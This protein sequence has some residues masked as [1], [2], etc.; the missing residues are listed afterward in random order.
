MEL[1]VGVGVSAAV[2]LLLLNAMGG[3]LLLIDKWYRQDYF[4]HD[5]GHLMAGVTMIVSGVMCAG[6]F[7]PACRRGRSGRDLYFVLSV[8]CGGMA[9]GFAMS[10]VWD[11]PYILQHHRNLY[12]GHPTSTLVPFHAAESEWIL[13]NGWSIPPYVDKLVLLATACGVLTT[14]WLVSGAIGSKSSALAV[15]RVIGF[16]IT[17]VVLSCSLIGLTLFSMSEHTVNMYRLGSFSDKYGLRSD[18]SSDDIDFLPD[19]W[20]KSEFQ[21]PWNQMSPLTLPYIVALKAITCLVVLPLGCQWYFKSLFSHVLLVLSI[22]ANATMIV[23]ASPVIKWTKAAGG[24]LKK[25]SSDGFKGAA[26]GWNDGGGWI[27]LSSSTQMTIFGVSCLLLILLEVVNTILKRMN[28][29]PESETFSDVEFGWGGTSVITNRRCPKAKSWRNSPWLQ[30]HF[31]KNPKNQMT[32][33]TSPWILAKNTKKRMN[34]NPESETFSDVEF[35]WGG[36]SVITNRRCPKA[37]SWRNSPWLQTH[38]AK[39]PKNQMTNWTSPWI[40]AKNTKK[41]KYLNLQ[42]TDMMTLAC[43]QT[44]VAENR[45]NLSLQRTDTMYLACLDPV[46]VGHGSAKTCGPRT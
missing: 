3:Y 1:T 25:A 4:S 29:N 6:L 42:R 36:T 11:L 23:V 43:L 26:S 19:A 21:Q 40:L 18:Y 8:V 24:F 16:K 32:N 35:G 31:A 34:L 5:V 13:I 22:L 17:V 10:Y 28:L 30:T 27:K 2:A 38:F 39:N 37:K 44:D 33:W 45:N 9:C 20:F 7:V 41:R 12:S 46:I 14:M 15:C